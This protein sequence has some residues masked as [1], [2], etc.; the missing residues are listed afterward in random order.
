MSSQIGFVILSHNCPQQL[1][2]LVLSLRRAYDNP[3]IAIHHDIDQTE[4]RQDEFPSDIRFVSPHVRTGWGQFSLVVAALRALE[5]LYKS[6]APDWFVLLSAADYPTAS[7]KQVLEDLASS[8]ADA[9]L[10]YRELPSAFEVRRTISYKLSFSGNF[11]SFGGLRFDPPYP[12]PA[13][14]AL[15]HLVLPNNLELAWRRYV[16]LNLW[17]P[18]IKS[19]PRIGRYTVHLPL[20]AWQTPFGPQFKCFYGDQWFTGNHKVADILLSPTSKH[21]QLRRHL[22]FRQVAD[23]CY[24]QTVL[25]NTPGLRLSGATRRFAEWSE[26]AGGSRGGSHPKELGISELPKIISSRAHFAR[27]FAPDSPVLNDLDKLL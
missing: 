10:D 11:V 15:S 24:Y 20:D 25:A 19:G 6:T 8:G 7:A 16:G 27:K 14:P 18:R 9:L 13:N 1:K 26:S 23:E 12:Q 3:P 2:R 21:L 17:L 4:V 5:L 22:R